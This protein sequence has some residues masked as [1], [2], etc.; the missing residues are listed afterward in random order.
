VAIRQR[1]RSARLL[2]VTLVAAS[3]AII[4]V[5]YRAGEEGPLAEA[6]RVMSSALAPMQRAVSSV[7]QPVSNFF[8]GLAEL[9]SLSQRN[10]ELQSQVDDLRTA[11]QLVQQLRE[12]I[13]DLEGLLGLRPILQ[14]TIPA[15]VIASGVS[16]F[17]WTITIGVGSED[18]VAVSMPV[19]TGAS[20]APRLVGRVIRVTPISSDVQ[21]LIDREFAVPATLST[22]HEAGIVEGRGE[23]E[24]RMA[25]VGPGIEVSETEPESVFT[26]G[27]EV[28]GEPGLYPPGIL[29]GTVS[30]AFSPPGA[31][32]SFVTIRPAV[33]F[34]T[35]QQVLVIVRG[36]AGEATS[37]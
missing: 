30:H 15:R 28:E 1:T 35:L 21:L 8:S 22:S 31:V 10:R 17:E 4:T 32:D 25:L 19:V 24:L 34:S 36:R 11:Q 18:G 9:P 7:V 6:G 29:I 3:L 12:E 20:D 13:E 5:D 2:V 33:D 16:N 27:F 26:L 23:D 14:R 37:P